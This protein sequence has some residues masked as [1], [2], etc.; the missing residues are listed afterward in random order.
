[1]KKKEK[2]QI[3]RRKDKKEDRNTLTGKQEKGQQK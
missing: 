3:E 1:M 2:E